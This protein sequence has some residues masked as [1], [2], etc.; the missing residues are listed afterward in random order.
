MIGRTVGNYKITQALGEGGVGMVYKGVDT[1]LDREVAIKVLRPELASQNDI[2]ERFRSEAVTLAKLNHP[3]IATLYSMFRQAN[4]LFMVLEFING[5]TL[6]R[7]L[8]RRGRIP[9]E[10]AVP[11]FCQ[12][13]E[14]ITYAHNRG[15]VHRDIKPGNMILTE[16][17]L[18][19]VLDFGIARL[20]GSNRMTRQGNVIGTLE[21]MSPEQVRGAETDAR[22]DVYGLGIM[23]YE[24]LT[25]RLPFES[26]NDFELMKMQ[27]E[28]APV[29]PRSLNP[30]IPDDIEASILKAI[31]KGPDGRFQAAGDFRDAL[32]DTG[33]RVQTLG[34]GTRYQNQ[35][36][37]RPSKPGI[38][39][40]APER[41]APLTPKSIADDQPINAAQKVAVPITLET[42]GRFRKATGETGSAI[43]A[44][45]QRSASEPKGTRLSSGTPTAPVDPG[46]LDLN[47][48]VRRALGMWES[49][50]IFTAPIGLRGV[51]ACVAFLAASVV[52]AIA[53]I[54]FIG[55]VP[56]ANDQ[57]NIGRESGGSNP[58]E[59]LPSE[60]IRPQIQIEP[61]PGPLLRQQPVSQPQV[62]PPSSP[63]IRIP[64]PAPTQ[65]PSRNVAPPN[66]KPK[67]PVERSKPTRQPAPKKRMNRLR[68]LM[69]DN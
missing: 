6:D 38:H 47:A 60:N 33:I 34:P 15:V 63:D 1:M 51:A 40:A 41:I 59:T 67:R 24:L 19:K 52:L 64:A 23:L 49:V 31:S 42:G 8:H 62:I 11:V 10:E 12:A 5:E 46:N 30:E 56:S 21:Y 28:M 14:G 22:S 57:T 45:L 35:R 65:D 17:G 27:T 55:D 18:V 54:I 58:P 36:N 7:V 50:Q 39:A 16:D 32:L 53:P 48:I 3:N 25:G 29:T 43:P 61:S 69:T 26:E 9:V 13:L 4:D 68:D 44:S 20:L 37:S 66:E 2:V